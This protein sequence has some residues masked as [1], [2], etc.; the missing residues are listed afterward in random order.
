[1]SIYGYKEFPTSVLAYGS[2]PLI[3]ATLT[4]PDFCDGAAYPK[5]IRFSGTGVSWLDDRDLVFQAAEDWYVKG[6]KEKGR[7]DK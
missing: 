2:H 6:R 3:G 5:T 4:L 1:M 7:G